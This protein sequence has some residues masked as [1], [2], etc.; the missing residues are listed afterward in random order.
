M[1]EGFKSSLP[2]ATDEL[3]IVRNMTSLSLATSFP[4]I[5]SDLSTGE[6]ILYGINLH[7]NSLVLFDRFKLENANMAVFAK[8]GAGKSYAVKLE[9]LRS[10]MFDTDVIVID[11][12]NEYKTL[13]SAVNGTFLDV[14]LNSDKRI[15]PFDLPNLGPEADGEQILRS[16][17]ITLA[18]LIRLMI[19]ELSPQE[20]A[21]LDRAIYETYAAKDITSDIKTHKNAPP[22][23]GDLEQLLRGMEG[24]TGMAQRLEKFTKGTFAGLFNQPTNVDMERGLVVFSIRDLEE[25]LRPI[26]MYVILNYI[27]NKVRYEK[28]KRLLILDE[29]WVLMQHEDS[30]KFVYSIAKRARKHWLGLTTITQDVEDFLDS[31]YG[32]AVVANSSLQLLMRQSPASIEKVADIFNLSA[33]ERFFLLEAAVGEGLFFAGNNHAAIRVMAS[34]IEDKIATSDP[35][36]LER[37]KATLGGER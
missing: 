35:A 13:A 5:S 11:P 24:G 14:S 22:T 15:D 9:V 36:Q 33:G 10:L 20:K 16:A 19:G 3:N 17:V 23:L 27:W 28:R 18:G 34:Y 4:F 26:G 29:A 21:I 2:Q 1:K 37:L 25:E 12:E 7:N 31:K 30:A 8:S 32:R 6:G